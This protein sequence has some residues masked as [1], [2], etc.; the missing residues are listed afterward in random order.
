MKYFLFAIYL[1]LSSFIAFGQKIDTTTTFEWDTTSHQFNNNAQQVFTYNGACYL[2]RYVYSFWDSASA[3]YKKYYR[4]TNSLLGNNATSQSLTQLWDDVGN[5][6]ENYEKGTYTY[7]TNPTL[8]SSVLYQSWQTSNSS[9]VN[10]RL[11]NYT[12]DAKG[13]NTIIV[14]K[15][16]KAGAWANSYQ[17]TYTYNSNNLI[18][19]FL[20][21]IWD[22]TTSNWVNFNLI[23]YAY[24]AF[25]KPFLDSG[26]KWNKPTASWINNYKSLYAYNANNFLVLWN[27]NTWDTT[28]LNYLQS[29][30]YQYINNAAG[31]AL[32]TLT[33]NFNGSNWDTLYNDVNHYNGCIL[34]VNL[35]SFTA[36]KDKDN[37]SLNWQTGSE[38]NVS[39]FNIQRST[40]GS[41]F[42]SIG[43]IKATNQ[44]G[45]NY[46]IN[47]PLPIYQS[48][49]NYYYRLEIVDKDGTKTYSETKQINFSKQEFSV[50]VFPNPATEYINIIGS[51][52]KQIT[53]TDLSGRQFLQRNINNTGISSTK[54]FIKNYS[55]GILIL[56]IL[57]N[58][59]EMFL[60]QLIIL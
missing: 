16:W 37:V 44:S 40:N 12:Y 10:S 32:E 48:T 5:K 52:I 51:N 30:Q 9:W 11:Y 18:T 53:I 6:W 41:D 15:E 21:E 1:F 46:N 57:N 38:I 42:E 54:F 24:T 47:D 59:M 33:L 29:Q 58:K 7:T 55:K 31:N 27:Y 36:I 56:K 2:T 49:R 45:N 20:Q 23:N 34:P 60:E 19:T 22:A 14:T 17:N 4:S 3:S 26:Q 39:H 25:N 35:I 8:A 50:K 28:T 13:N 43:Q